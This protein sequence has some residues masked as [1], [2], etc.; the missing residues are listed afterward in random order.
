MTKINWYNGKTANSASDMQKLCDAVNRSLLTPV[1]A[2]ADTKVVAVDNTNSQKML[3]IGDGLS[4]ENDTL[5]VSASGGDKLYQHNIVIKGNY[6]ITAIIITKNSDIFN[7]N[8]LINYL[9]ENYGNGF[10]SPGIQIKGGFYNE[11]NT[12]Y[13]LF[14][15][16]ELKMRYIGRTISINGTS[17]IISDGANFNTAIQY[18]TFIDTVIEL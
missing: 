1:S 11:L 4:I 14:L 13:E 15:D 18:D 17:L 12:P 8:S 5:K 3:T 9:N 16:T 2:P 6:C 7:E 10:N